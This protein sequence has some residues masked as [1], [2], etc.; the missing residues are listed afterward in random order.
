MVLTQ[1]DLELSFKVRAIRSY[2]NPRT[3][4][5][6]LQSTSGILAAWDRRFARPCGRLNPETATAL[7]WNSASNRRESRNSHLNYRQI[8]PFSDPFGSRGASHGAA[9]KS[10]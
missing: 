3:Q 9:L 5:S 8:R 7:L 4:K 1:N 10:I 2:P 6:G